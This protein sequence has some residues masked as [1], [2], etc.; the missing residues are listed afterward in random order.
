MKIAVLHGQKHHG[1]TWNATRLLLDQ[2][3]AS[4][5]DEFF[6]NDIPDCIGCFTCVLNDEEKCPHR[7]LIKPII[8]AIDQA[9]VIIVATPNYCMGMTG[10]LKTFFDHLAYR[11]LSHSPLGAMQN[12]IAVAIS[13]TAGAGAGVATKQIARQLF[14]WGIPKV[15]R[16][17][18]AVAAAKW[19]DVKPETKLKI[20][21]KAVKIAKKT[22][23]NLG[24]I[25]RGLRQ[26][27][28]F[29]MMGNM[30]K[31]GMGTPKDAAYWKKQG[32]I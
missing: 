16:L 8:E 30:Q 23:K 32:W 31:S 3:G 1:S 5:C 9:D 25:R 19:D 14:W 24:R 10:Q 20:E 26:K 7:S 6:V 21:Q 17:N 27:F 13:T 28:L 2:L 11:W 18:A 12:K 4:T 15:Y 22:R 29:K